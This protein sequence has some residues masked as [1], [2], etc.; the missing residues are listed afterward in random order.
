[1]NIKRGFDAGLMLGKR[2]RRWLNIKPASGPR[3]V[4][5]ELLFKPHGRISVAMLL[6]PRGRKVCRAHILSCRS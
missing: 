5:D 1:M 2:L 6:S 3:S 4:F